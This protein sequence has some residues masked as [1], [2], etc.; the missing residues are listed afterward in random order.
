MGAVF[1]I[2][3]KKHDSRK[4]AIERIENFF[5]NKEEFDPKYVRKIKRLAMA[6][7]IKL[8]DK[9]KKFCKRCFADLRRNK[10]KTNN[11]F[12]TII[13][14]RCGQKARFKIN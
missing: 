4:E 13:C 9:R 3:M 5:S 1:I 6:Y 11:D 2:F 8:K 14:V 12:K 7:N 10:G